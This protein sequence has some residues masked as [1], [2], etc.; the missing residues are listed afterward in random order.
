MFSIN[1]ASEPCWAEDTAIGLTPAGHLTAQLPHPND[2]LEITSFTF[3]LLLMIKQVISPPSKYS[4]E[5]I[6]VST[7]IT[8]TAEFLMQLLCCL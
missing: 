3:W 1:I 5:N 7:G 8:L 4:G 6:A 2:V